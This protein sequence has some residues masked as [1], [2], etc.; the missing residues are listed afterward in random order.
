[1]TIALSRTPQP[2]I[3]TGTVAISNTGG[4]SSRAC[5]KSNGTATLRAQSQ[6]VVTVSRWMPSESASTRSPSPG[7]VKTARATRAASAMC[8]TGANRS[9]HGQRNSPNAA[10]AAGPMRQAT[11]IRIR[12]IRPTGLRIRS[13]DHGRQASTR[14]ASAS[15]PITQSTRTE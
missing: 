14:T 12:A 5:V 10:K 11:P 8:R 13:S 4:I 9:S 6:A 15:T 2:A 3:E 1:V 7:L